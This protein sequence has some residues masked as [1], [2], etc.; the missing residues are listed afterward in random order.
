MT[1]QQIGEFVLNKRKERGYTQKELADK[2]G[3]RRQAIIEIEQAQC[4]YGIEAL[5][6]VLDGLGCELKPTAKSKRFNFSE[7]K[8]LTK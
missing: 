3:M 5:I 6:Q 1:K 4:N 7:T 2:L 8:S